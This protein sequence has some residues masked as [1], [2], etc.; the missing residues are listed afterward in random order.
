MAC[1]LEARAPFLDHRLYE[2]VASVSDNHL[3]RG[4]QTKWLLRQVVKA[5]VPEA[6]TARPKS[7]FG[8]PPGEW[9]RDPLRDWAEDLLDAKTL[10]ETGLFD[11]EYVHHLWKQHISGRYNR[12]DDLWT[13]LMFEAWRRKWLK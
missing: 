10:G 5:R 4:G 12:Q 8:I 3:I 11:V 7:G 1:S 6:L 13:V 9:L 2:Y